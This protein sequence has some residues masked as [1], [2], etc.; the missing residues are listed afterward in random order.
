MQKFNKILTP[1]FLGLSMSL[2]ISGGSYASVGGWK[3][4]NGTWKYYKD[5]VALKSWHKLDN[6]W[7]FFNE[8][9]SL[10]TGWFLDANNNWYFLDSSNGSN[11]GMLL[12]GWQWIDGYC[13]YFEPFDPATLGQMYADRVVDGYKLN[14]MGRWVDENGKEHYDATKGIISSNKDLNSDK[15]LDK[16][17]PEIQKRTGS[18][19]AGG[20]ICRKY[21]AT[22]G[23]AAATIRSRCSRRVRQTGG[24]PTP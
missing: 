10:K 3:S 18:S 21:R 6:N 15:N 24:V 22:I 7:Y 8:D 16:K 14:S 17:A 11:Q 5:Y 23:L 2:L 12:S 20:G 13:Y 1:A 9:G 19:N 4:E